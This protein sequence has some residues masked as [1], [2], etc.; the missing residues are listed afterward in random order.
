VQ[1]AVS[2]VEF[3]GKEHELG[4]IIR[5]A[6]TIFGHSIGHGFGVSERPN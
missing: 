6:Y 4:G 3:Q 2:V 5:T 1:W